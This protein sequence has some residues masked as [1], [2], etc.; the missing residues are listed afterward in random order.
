ME[1]HVQVVSDLDDMVTTPFDLLV[2]CYF[3]KYAN[4]DE[5]GLSKTFVS[6]SRISEEYHISKK[7]IL[8]SLENLELDKYLFR[9]RRKGTSNM[10]IFNPSKHFEAFSYEFLDTDKLTNK[11]KAYLIAAQKYMFITQDSGKI[12]FTNKE[13]ADKLNIT[14]K[15]VRTYND[16]LERKGMLT[17]VQNKSRDIVDNGGCRTTTKIYNINEYFQGIAYLIKQQ[18]EQ[19]NSNTEEIVKHTQELAHLKS[20]FFKAIELLKKMQKEKEEQA[21]EIRALKKQINATVKPYEDDMM[22]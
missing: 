9:E 12:S 15:T 8:K 5:S 20:E 4:V 18:Q 22:L 19:I 6:I 10:I 11:E 1:Q 3:K 16:I 14:E 21:K 7:T 2:Y 13:L 17:V